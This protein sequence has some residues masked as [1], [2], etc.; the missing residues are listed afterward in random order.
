MKLCLQTL[1][2]LRWFAAIA[3]ATVVNLSHAIVGLPGT[4]DAFWGTA[5]NPPGIAI[6]RVAGSYAFGVCHRDSA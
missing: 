2:P 4:L 6:T 1:V 5:N 3:L